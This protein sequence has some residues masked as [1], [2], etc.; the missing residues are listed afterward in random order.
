MNVTAVIPARGGSKGIPGKNT[1]EVGGV[2]LVARAVLAC[3]GAAHVNRVVV[4]TDDAAIARA[5]LAAG[6]EV[7][8]RPAELGSDRASSESAL[9]HALDVLEERHSEP[10]DV[11]VFVQCTSPFTTPEEVEETVLAVVRDGADSA[12][13]AVPFHGFLWGTGPA[14]AQDRHHAHGVNHDSS[15]RLRRQDR[16]PE[17]LESGAVYAMRAEGF[18]RHGHRFFG[19]TQLVPTAPERAIEIDEPGDL[20]RARALAP[21]LDPRQAPAATPSPEPSQTPSQNPSQYP[22]KEL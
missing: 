1:A 22:G 21:L 3:R 9:L 19:R 16:T 10:V 20:A 8:D 13:T 6:A 12:F 17:Y 14:G 15:V 4:S 2:P 18:R 11:L 7:V 5:A